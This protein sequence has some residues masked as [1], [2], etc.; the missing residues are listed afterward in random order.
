VIDIH[1]QALG[2]TIRISGTPFSLRYR[3]DRMGGGRTSDRFPN[4]LAGWSLNVHYAY[5]TGK[6]ILY[7]GDGRRRI[8]G[9]TADQAGGEIRIPSEDGTVLYIFDVGGKH[10]RTQNSLTGAVH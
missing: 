9:M 5:D 2:E 1:N 10:L 3:S 8:P 7:T 4:S 6:R